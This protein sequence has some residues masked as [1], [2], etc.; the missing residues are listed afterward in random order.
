MNNGAT[1]PEEYNYMKDIKTYTTKEVADIL[2]ITT[3]GLYDWIKAGKI[4]GAKCGKN[5]LFTEET[6]K[7]FLTPEE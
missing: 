5:W 4:K 3:R 2:H 6:I 7:A 1:V